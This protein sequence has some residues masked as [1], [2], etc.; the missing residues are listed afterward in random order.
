MKV[1]NCIWYETLVDAVFR[2]TLIVLFLSADFRV[3]MHINLLTDPVIVRKLAQQSAYDL[4][5]NATVYVKV[6]ELNAAVRCNICW[7]DLCCIWS[8][9]VVAIN[10]SVFFLS[11]VCHFFKNQKNCW[12]FILANYSTGIC[13]LTIFCTHLQNIFRVLESWIT[14]LDWRILDSLK[15]SL[16]I[17]CFPK[18]P[19]VVRIYC[20]RSAV[21]GRSQWHYP[22]FSYS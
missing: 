7:P 6:I 13:Q 16:H 22:S 21:V 18:K 17:I 11:T 4:Q 20:G 10:L 1:V 12:Q 14:L 2:W 5:Y 3:H 19:G 9:R 8:P 15:V